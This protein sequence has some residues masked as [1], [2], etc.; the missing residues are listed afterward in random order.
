MTAFTTVLV[1]VLTMIA[2]M[3]CG[4]L[5]VKSKKGVAAHAKTMSA[6]LIYVLSPAMVIS[7]FQKM[8]YSVQ[9]LVDIGI[10]FAASLLVQFLFFLVLFFAIKRKFTDAKYRLLTI[11]SVL[12]NVGFFGLPLVT[13]LFPEEPMAACYSSV[14]VMTMNLLVFTVGVF[15]ITGDK[16]YISWKSVLCNPTTVS[17][18]IAFPLFLLDWHFPAAVLE[19]LTLL[20]RTTTPICMIVLGMRLATV[21]LKSLFT[22]PFAYLVCALKLVVFP[23]TA[24]LCVAFL[25]FLS[26]TF[27]ACM[28]V[29]SAVPSGAVILS[30]AELHECEQE[31]AAN[32]VL[33]TTLLSVV[34]APLLILLI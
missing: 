16:K 9:T 20:G 25:P 3:A 2:Y 10:F 11:G 1:N 7:S 4:F 29:L 5:L 6:M 30:L 17:I 8:D 18:L 31:L 33:L 34:T 12:G 27:R 22:R 23:L 28:L 32:V 15:M 24:Y 13:S 19:P 21:K 26:E 14:Y